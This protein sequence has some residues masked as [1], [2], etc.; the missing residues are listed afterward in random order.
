[1]GDFTAP[2]SDQLALARQ[3][4]DGADDDCEYDRDEQDV[5]LGR[6]VEASTYF[7]KGR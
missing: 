6:R 7:V 3:I 5:D 1:M 4:H 2:S